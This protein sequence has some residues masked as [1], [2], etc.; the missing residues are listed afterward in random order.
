GV[1]PSRTRSSALDRGYDAEAVGERA[2]RRC[3]VFGRKTLPRD[4]E[5][6]E[7]VRRVGAAAHPAGEVPRVRTPCIDLVERLPERAGDHEDCP[8]ALRIGTVGS[9]TDD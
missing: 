8:R 1:P 7:A 2:A 6:D 5:F 4:D 9:I 3:D